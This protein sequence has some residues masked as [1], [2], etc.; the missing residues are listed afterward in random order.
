MPSTTNK[1]KREYNGKPWLNPLSTWK[2]IK[3]DPLI[4]T[5]NETNLMQPIIQLIK[6]T[7]KPR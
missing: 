7:S 1:N 5:T 4:K 3:V 2:K 6:E